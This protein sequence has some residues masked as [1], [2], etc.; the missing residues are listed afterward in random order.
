[1]AATVEN[2]NSFTN[3]GG[4]TWSVT[5][6]STRWLLSI[7]GLSGGTLTDLNGDPRHVTNGGPWQL[8]AVA[9]AGPGLPKAIA[10]ARRLAGPGN[11]QVD[12]IGPA[13]LDTHAHLYMLSG[14][15]DSDDIEDV[16]IGGSASSAT[17]GTAQKCALY[18]ADTSGLLIGAWISGSVINYS[19]LGG[20]TMRAEVDGVVSTSRTGEQTLAA[21]GPD[22]RTATA[23]AAAPWAAV[24]IAI[25]GPR[26]P[27]TF[28]T[29]PLKSRTELA[30]GADP[31]ADPSAWAGLWTDISGDVDARDNGIT[32]T[33]GRADEAST[34][35]PST[36]TTTLDNTA[37]KYGRLNP[38]GPYYG[39]L[40]KNTPI[41]QW[42]DAGSGWLMRYT[43]FISEFP[44]RSL[45]GEADEIMPIQADGLTRRL[46]QGK[47][48][49]SPLYRAI[50]HDGRYHAYWP[51]ETDAS[52]GDPLGG[53]PMT[54]T[55]PVS[56]GGDG[57]AGSAGAMSTDVGGQASARVIGMPDLGGWTISWWL[58][59]P[60]DFDAAVDVSVMVNW[61]IP[62]SLYSQWF[63]YVTPGAGGGKIAVE[64]FI[65]GGGGVG[66]IIG[67]TDLRGRGAVLVTVNALDVGANIQ[68]ELLVNDGA[69]EQID[70]S[71]T[72][73]QTSP[74]TGIGING[75]VDAGLQPKGTV[76]HLRVAGDPN[77]IFGENWHWLLLAGRGYAGEVAADRITRISAEEG[78]PAVIVG[79]R[80]V[81]EAMGPQPIGS[82]LDL[83]R[84]CE[85]ADGGVLF[86]QRGGRLA[87]QTRENR[88]NADA[89]L[90]LDY[91]AKDVAPPLEPTD[92]DQRTRNRWTIDRPGGGSAQVLDQAH[93][94]QVGE[95]DD[96]A[97]VN[98]ADDDQLADQA[99]WR[100]HLGTVDDLRYPAI[101]PNLNGRPALI[102]DWAQIDVG[103]AIA[104]TN[105][106][107]DLPPGTV[108]MFAE[109]YTETIDVV[110]W[111]AVPNCSPGAPWRVAVA[112]DPVLGRADTDGSRLASSATSTATT[113]SV[114]T[115]SGPLW[116]V[117]GADTPMDLM[118]GGEQ[119]TVRTVGTALD[120]NPFFDVDA[121]SWTAFNGSIVR[122]TAQVYPDD[123]A[124]ASLLITPDGINA[125]GGANSASTAVGS[126]TAGAVYTAMLWVYSP[127]GW[128]DIRA[129]VDWQD[130]S[131][132]LLSNAFAPAA[133][134]VPA[135]VWTHLSATLTAPA[136]VSRASVRGRH[137]GTPPSSAIWYA[138]AIRLVPVASANT[139]PQPMTVIR[140]IN[141]VV[142]A[143]T[144][145]TD[146]RLAQPMILSS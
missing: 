127:G 77:V 30:L 29:S 58:S 129:G 38:V 12:V 11:Y 93:I 76:S 107:R 26:G 97:T 41:R 128:S 73:D 9:D 54:L 135:G 102:D 94:D 120:A 55:G 78:I 142:K 111:E 100:V 16:F 146:V 125:N 61:T 139:S 48:L 118:I 145:G 15:R 121:S 117:D 99:G 81:S 72:G 70:A 98:V 19:S 80:G 74:I 119:V 79:A 68:Y 51:L 69:L 59:V 35:S 50:T 7:Q 28:P 14:L 44:P 123:S 4:N 40:A 130:A 64:A 84:D 82:Y 92:D 47:T 144:A 20:P 140:S 138:W 27:V 114:A 95:Y 136:G 115:T 104:M 31:G 10:W 2:Y 122:S 113:L 116:T 36:L 43:G 132:A 71:L 49:R 45:G 18:S 65:P 89:T 106:G 62:G 37:G 91:A 60:A 32:I 1:M 17:G 85:T 105:P 39:K 13:G 83:V 42:F 88:Y 133:T 53:F 3:Q 66:A 143:Q 8:V 126:V 112:D 75:L 46:A 33:R 24:T 96:S 21:S 22:S 101:S 103:K 6:I 25:R 90:T 5:A 34:I 63:A 137:A 67:T 56:F 87:Y 57:P 23:S 131:G 109:G 124:A 52:S 110:S 141:G 86:E 134:A 108:A